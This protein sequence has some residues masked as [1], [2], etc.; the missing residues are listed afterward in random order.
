MEHVKSFMKRRLSIPNCRDR[1]TAQQ[2]AAGN[3]DTFKW[4]GM[5]SKDARGFVVCEACH[6]DNIVGTPFQSRFA[7][8]GAQGPQDGWTCDG[9]LPYVLRALAELSKSNDWAG[10]VSGVQ[11]RMAYPKCEGKDIAWNEGVWFTPRRKLDNFHVCG[12]C[13]MD[14]LELTV[15]AH[16]FE[17]VATTVGFDAWMNMLGTRWTCKMAGSNIAMS[18][19]LDAYLRSKD[20]DGFWTMASDLNALVPCTANGIIRGKW[21]TIAG[22]GGAEAEAARKAFD[23]CEAC[24]LGIFKTNQLDHFLEPAA[25]RPEDTIVCDFC[26]AAPR[27]NQYLRKFA[28]AM[29][30][31]VFGYYSDYIVKFA[32]VAPCPRLDHREKSTWWGY[33]QVLFCQDCHLSFVADTT[34]GKHHL[35]YYDASDSRAQICQMW[36]PR[37][38]RQWQQVCEAGAPGSAAS[39]EALDKFKAFGQRRLE[40]Y[41]QTVPRIRFL[42]AMKEMKMMNAMHQGQ[43]SLMYSGMNSMAVLSDTTDGYAHGNSSLGWYETEHGATGAQM[44]DNMQAGFADANRM[45]E[46]AQIVQ[47]QMMWSEVE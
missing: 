16:E 23:I 31:S 26:P 21:W 20:Y 15:F 13:Y 42:R 44:F 37:M 36:S 2:T 3:K 35:Q 30:R 10:F 7:A 14:K 28:E 46:W 6:E 8:L 9:A 18:F 1:A 25:R 4:F 5:V 38:R 40:V 39:D 12:A 17:A 22:G 19:A 34:L 33:D 43:L 11:R 29:D 32:P 47:L 45:D 41:L 27:F 24:F